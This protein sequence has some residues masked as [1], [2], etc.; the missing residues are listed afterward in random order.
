MKLTHT[1]R[2]ILGAALAGL[3]LAG[4]G[5]ARA[6]DRDDQIEKTF[7]A[8]HV[9]KTD[10]QKTDLSIDSENGVVDLKGSVENEDQKRLAED[11]VRGIPGVVRVE[12]RLTVTGNQKEGSDD[13]IALKVRGALLLHRNVSATDT[14]VQVQNG[15]VTLTG[16]ARSEAEK[17]LAAEYAND[18]KGVVRVD[19]QIRVVEPADRDRVTSSTNPRNDAVTERRTA[20]ERIDDASITAKL[21]SSLAIRKSTSAL[22]T[23]VTTRNGVVTITGEAKNGAE[24][25][26]VTKLA[27]DIEGVRSVDNEMTVRER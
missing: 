23:D 10:L 27:E 6:D 13:W 3:L 2:F 22:H 16:T 19:N 1:P 26:L 17:A 4:T 9:Y 12:N 14:H 11:T 15:L 7:K 18:I 5:L 24:K 8:S 20:G 25:D 21:K